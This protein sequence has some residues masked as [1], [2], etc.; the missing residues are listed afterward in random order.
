MAV[1]AGLAVRPAH[2]ACAPSSVGC[3][4]TFSRKGRRGRGA[5]FEDPTEHE[6][7][8]V[9]LLVSEPENAKALPAQPSV[10][11][12]VRSRVV[13]RTIGFDNQPMSQTHEVND[14]AADRHLAAEFQVFEAAIAQEPPKQPL[15]RRRCPSQPAH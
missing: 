10:A 6:I 3:A 11:Y 15:I 4:D 5:E 14:I 8:C 1:T 9:Q 13:K 7:G 2:K 12:G